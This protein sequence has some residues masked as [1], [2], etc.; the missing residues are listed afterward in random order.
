MLN[1]SITTLKQ[2]NHKPLTFDDTVDVKAELM[3]RNP[4]I[5]DMTPVHATGTILFSRGDYTVDGDLKAEVTLP[6]TRSL[7]PVQ[8][9]IDFHF[10]ETYLADESHSDQYEEDD[11]LIPLTSDWLDLMPAVKDNLLL[12]LPL[13]VLTKE[14]E[15]A[16]T[17]PS[18]DDWTL[19]TEEEAAPVPPEERPNNPF[20]G[21]QGMFDDK[22]DDSDK[23]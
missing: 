15:N 18:G 17:L 10:T 6:S 23:Q 21:L 13:R 1:W 2:Y 7:V 8:V 14:E 5:I 20:A 9:S 19:M 16:V 12:S 11:V 22:G 3:E 4:D